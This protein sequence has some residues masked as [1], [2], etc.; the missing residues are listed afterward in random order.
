MVLKDINHYND[1]EPKEIYGTWFDGANY[2]VESGSIYKIGRIIIIYQRFYLNETLNKGEYKD[3]Y[4][5]ND[6]INGSS[7]SM[8]TCVGCRLDTDLNI[9]S[10]RITE[11]GLI[12]IYALTD[13]PKNT[14]LYFNMVYVSAA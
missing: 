11:Q 3:I 1:L 7:Y 2:I 14:T 12:T 6:N 5:F 9:F 10:V 4:Q 13:I 8:C